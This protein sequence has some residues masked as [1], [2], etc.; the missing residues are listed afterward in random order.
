I[1][2]P[3]K[4]AVHTVSGATACCDRHK[5]AL[6]S[7]MGFMGAHSIANPLEFPME[8]TNCINEA[9]KGKK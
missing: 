9:K 8:C 6:I 5:D 2:F 7:L 4:W 3:A 1:Q